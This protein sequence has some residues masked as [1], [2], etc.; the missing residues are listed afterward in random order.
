[1]TIKEILT[2]SKYVNRFIS[3]I[4]SKTNEVEWNS[5]YLSANGYV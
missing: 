2:I 3:I 1:M 4:L 5:G